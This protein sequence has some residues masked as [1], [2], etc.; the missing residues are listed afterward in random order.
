M[1]S[2]DARLFKINMAPGFSQETTRYAEEGNWFEGDHVRFRRGRPENIRGYAKKDSA[3]FK[4][5]ARDLL[6][7]TNDNGEKKVSF[8]TEKKWYVYDSDT[9]YD[10]TPV[11]STQALTSAFSTSVGSYE[12]N[13]SIATH[14]KSVGDFVV[15]SSATEIGGSIT[16]DGDYEVKSVVDVNNF[17]VSAAVAASATEVSAG[18]ATI[19][20]LL[21]TG[22]T[23]GVAGLGFGAGVFNAGTSTTGVRAWN[24]AASSSN[25]TFAMSQWTLENWGV[26]MLGCSRGGRIY[27][28]DEDASATPAR[29]TLVT[30]SPTVNNYIIVSP[31]DRHLIS[32]GTTGVAA[33]YSALRVRWADQ[34]NY[35]DWTPSVSSTAGEVDLVGGTEIRGAVRTRNQINVFTDEA[36]FGM[37]Y[38]GPPSIFGFQQLGSNCGLVG[39][40]AAVDYDG[41]VMWMGDNNFYRFD[42]SVKNMECPIRRYVFDRLNTSHKEKVYAGINSEFKEVVWLYPSEDGTE[43]DSYVLHNPEENTW[44]FGT[45]KWTTYYDSGVFDNTIT[46]GSDSYLFDNEPVG[47]IDFDGEV[48]TSYIES[49]EFDFEEGKNIMFVDKIIPDFTIS[50][51]NISFTL[52]T[53]MYPNGPET[54]KGPYMI[55]ATTEKTDLRARGRQAKV[56][57]SV[58]STDTEWRWGDPRLSGQPD[59]MR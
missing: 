41:V 15:F 38:I 31:N 30:A 27:L 50:D 13:V 1:S 16:L 53:R 9:F 39:V 4:G 7:W 37:R 47:V 40:H 6:I 26:D 23:E 10:I 43:C 33:D 45:S 17:I 21:G 55:N 18:T 48:N 52:T 49:A 46:T 11:V 42:G 28:F 20:Y 29:A 5:T 25:I 24:T 2:T 56:R 57:V 32:L 19:N 8:A 44:V 59:G 34:E 51:G 3:T 35:N 36:L 22:T 54:T 12:V 14:N 58:A